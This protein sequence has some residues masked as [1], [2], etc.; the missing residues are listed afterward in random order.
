MEHAQLF[1]LCRKGQL[2][3]ILSEDGPSQADLF[4][5]SDILPLGES[6]S[7]FVNPERIREQI[8]YITDCLHQ[9]R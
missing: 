4:L 2:L 6:K 9:N 3:K 5:Q 8:Q 1:L 7:D